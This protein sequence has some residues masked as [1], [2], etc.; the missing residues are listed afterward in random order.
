M[1]VARPIAVFSLLGF[2]KLTLQ[3]KT[4]ISWVGLRGAVPI[5]LATMPLLAGVEEADTI[6]H[7]VFFVVLTSTLLQGTS[8]PTG[9]QVARSGGRHDHQAAESA[10]D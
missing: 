8:I 2:T 3:Q 6:F 1:L 5:V 7:V 10:R 4:L 9:G